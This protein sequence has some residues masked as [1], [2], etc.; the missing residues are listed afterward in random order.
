MNRNL[1]PHKEAIA[2]MYIFGPEY[3]SQKKGCM[4]YFGSLSEYQKNICRG[5]VNQI[6]DEKYPKEGENE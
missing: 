5:C 3:S 4:D 1:K 2:M 6:L